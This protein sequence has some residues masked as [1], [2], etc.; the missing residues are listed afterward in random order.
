ME[1]KQNNWQRFA[2]YGFYLSL[3]A[4]FVSISLYIV[5]RKINLPLQISLGF[6]VIGLALFAILDPARVRTMLHRSPGKI[7]KQ[8]AG[9]DV[10][11][12]RNSGGG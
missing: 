8:R 2:P 5:Q 7:W 12:L 11:F 3:I 10:G 4:A 6:I 1:M 9:H